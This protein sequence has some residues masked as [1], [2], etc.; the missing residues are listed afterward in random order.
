MNAELVDQ[1]APT[2]DVM[3]EEAACLLCGGAEHVSILRGADIPVC[4]G[5]GRQERLSHFR[6]V[7][8]ARCGLHFTNPRPTPES[9]GHFYP[10][11]YRPHSGKAHH[12]RPLRSWYPLD[13]LHCAAPH[14]ARLLDFGC[15]AGHFLAAMDRAGW[16]VTGLD[17]SQAAIDAIRD[18]IGLPA[19]AGTLPHEAFEPQS[20]DCITMWHALEHV[21]D[22]LAVVREARRLLVSDGRLIVAVP[23]FASWS[24]RRFGEGWFG[25]DL[26]RHLTHFESATLVQMLQSAGLRVREV[27]YS[28][29]ADWIRAS[30]LRARVGL[31]SR[32]MKNRT[33][34]ALTAR[35]L[36]RR[37]EQDV[38]MV[39]AERA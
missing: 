7:K 20:F 2:P 38:V 37:D 3:L 29:H 15:G 10:P 6:V 23:N 32:L 25:L 30:A 39:M 21:H 11:E 12:R 28:R 22:P 35:C 4:P 34:A 24:R 9:I 1:S 36:V 26:P 5:I 16:E 14:Y 19:V 17:V 31:A 18:E 33:I 13:W 8:C 27:R